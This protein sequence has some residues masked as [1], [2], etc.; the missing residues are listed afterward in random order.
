MSKF[1]QALHSGKVLLMDGAMGTELLRRGLPP[2]MSGEF[3]N[4]KNPD[5]V[6]SIQAKYIAAGAVCLL[7]NTFLARDTSHPT[8]ELD[9]NQWRSINR[10]GLKLLR[11]NDRARFVLGDIGPPLLSVSPPPGAYCHA[12]EECLLQMEWLEGSDVLFMETQSSCSFT[13][14]VLQRSVDDVRRPVPIVS[15]TFAN[16]DSGPCLYAGGETPE[17]VAEFA[18]QYRSSLLALGVNCGKHM[19]IDDIIQVLRRYREVTGLPLL[20]RPNAGSPRQAGDSWIYP[21]TPTSFAA[22]VPELVD[23]GVTLLGGCC[24]TTPAHIEAMGEVLDKMGVLWKP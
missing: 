19:G 15:F 21:R 13:G 20:A 24:G 16:S 18:E 8:Q 7:T 11:S 14:S 4:V 5:A 10:A 6:R 1:L 17:Q 3:W 23:A 9:N 22:R 12:I 2:G